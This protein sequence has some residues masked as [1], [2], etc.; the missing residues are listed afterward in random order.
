MTGGTAALTNEDRKSAVGMAWAL[1]AVFFF[2]AN[3][4]LMKL[5]SSDYSLYQL[6]FIRA[7]VGLL[8]V[9]VIIVPTTGSLSMLRTQRLG[10]HL[11][12]GSC[13]VFANL[14][15]FL[16]LAA[17][18]LAEA[19]AIFFI[20]PLVIALASIFFLGETV[21]PRRWAAIAIGL[22]GVFIVLRPGT[23]A[24]QIAA[25]LPLAAAIGYAALHILTRRIGD[26]ENATAMVFYIQFTF[27]IASAIAG[28]ALG[29]GRFEAF[30]HP[31]LEFLLR[32]WTWPEPGD[33][34]L[35]GLIGVI[36]SLG[37]FMISQAYR[38]SEAALVAPVEYIALPLAVF[39]GFAV[40]GELPDTAA[41]IGIALVMMSGAILVWREGAVR[42][43]RRPAPGRH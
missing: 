43:W 6:V 19:V 35:I 12:R 26:T 32:A 9:V 34:V 11:F 40:F 38:R 2:S 20:A 13:V 7:V 22:I 24:F 17:M 1:M 33:A 4:V 41:W 31:S 36:S 25:L 18:P 3:D 39:W 14:C 29:D 8:F 28:L 37:G 23:D 27:L 16:G 42:R 15:F 10:M 5:L 30:E 21:G